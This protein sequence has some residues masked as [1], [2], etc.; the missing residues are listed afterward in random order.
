[1]GRLP[2]SAPGTSQTHTGGRKGI[3]KGVEGPWQFQGPCFQDR[4]LWFW[5]E[6]MSL[7]QKKKHTIPVAFTT[8]TGI[9]S[10]LRLVP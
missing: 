1:M 3:A 7:K 8:K 2:C 6:D 10:H 4:Y 9:T 5:E